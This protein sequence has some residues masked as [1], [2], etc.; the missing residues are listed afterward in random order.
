MVIGWEHAL[1]FVGA[2]LLVYNRPDDIVTLHFGAD[3]LGG[4]IPIFL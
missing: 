2:E 4:K 1:D 3:S